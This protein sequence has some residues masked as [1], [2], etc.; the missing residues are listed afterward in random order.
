VK[1]T[2]GTGLRTHL[3]KVKLEGPTGPSQ[4][5]RQGRLQLTFFSHQMYPPWTLIHIL[6]FFFKFGLK[7]VELLELK[8]NLATVFCSG[9]HISPLHDAA[10]IQVSDIAE[11]FLLNFVAGR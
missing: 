2:H 8:S 6:Q 4:D 1:Q 3:F 11:I 9:S 7:F 10:A 5:E